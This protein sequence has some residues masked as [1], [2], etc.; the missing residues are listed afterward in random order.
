LLAGSSGT[1]DAC[2]SDTA[3]HRVGL[4]IIG[5]RWPRTAVAYNFANQLIKRTLNLSTLF[6]FPNFIDTIKLVVLSLWRS[7][8]INFA[9]YWVDVIHYLFPLRF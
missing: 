8:S 5:H 9:I 2:A 4:A 6:T 7:P 1:S 3:L